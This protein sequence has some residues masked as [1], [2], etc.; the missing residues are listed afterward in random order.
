MEK[1]T[2]LCS[3]LP[4]Q[5]IL[6]KIKFE[7]FIKICVLKKEKKKTNNYNNTTILWFMFTNCLNESFP[8]NA[9]SNK[10]TLITVAAHS[11]YFSVLKFPINN[12]RIKLISLFVAM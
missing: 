11:L 1:K 5:T 10:Q 3:F 4:K 8:I 9:N 2:F 7:V 12:N 6:W